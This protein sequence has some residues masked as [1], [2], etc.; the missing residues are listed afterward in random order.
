MLKQAHFKL[1]DAFLDT[2]QIVPGDQINRLF[3][4]AANEG[5]LPFCKLLFCQGAD[6][7]HSSPGD[8]PLVAAISSGEFKTVKWLVMNGADINQVD[9][10]MTPLFWAIEACSDVSS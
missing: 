5:N 1:Y 9:H 3:V 6:I 10:G 8:S 7:N 2:K 4:I